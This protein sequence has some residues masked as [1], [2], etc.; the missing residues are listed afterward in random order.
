MLCNLAVDIFSSRKS[1]YLSFKFF[2]IKFNPFYKAVICFGFFQFREIFD[3]LSVFFDNDY[4]ACL[5]NV[6]RNGDRLTV[7]GKVSMA[8]DLDR[9]SVV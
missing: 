8:Y 7:Y 6:G 5:Y 2:S 9:K 4:V 3:T 1:Q